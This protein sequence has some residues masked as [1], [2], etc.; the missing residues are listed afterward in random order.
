MHAW[1]PEQSPA[2]GMGAIIDA[3]FMDL[4]ATSRPTTHATHK[5]ASRGF[6]TGEYRSCVERIGSLY[7]NLL[8]L[9]GEEGGLP[10]HE[11]DAL[12]PSVR[13]QTYLTVLGCR[14][15]HNDRGALIYDA[16][17]VVR[18]ARVSLAP[19]LS[20]A[21]CE[22]HACLL[23]SALTEAEGASALLVPM[24]VR[25]DAVASAGCSPAGS[26]PDPRLCACLYHR[27]AFCSPPD[28]RLLT[29]D[30]N[31]PLTPARLLAHATD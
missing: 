24:Q 22:H 3:M 20:L 14:F 19:A 4:L 15:D 16:P 1:P 27:P 2:C 25:E 21:R 13:L 10:E 11:K 17:A 23:H 12:P 30:F 31:H 18:L 29:S 9:L 5:R 8:Q 26:P 28:Q 7:T 6:P